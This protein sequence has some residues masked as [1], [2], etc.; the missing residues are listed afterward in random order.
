MQYFGQKFS[1]DNISCSC[2]NGI[3]RIKK[4]HT[5]CTKNFEKISKKISKTY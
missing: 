2:K 4:Q 1:P 3:K 5:N